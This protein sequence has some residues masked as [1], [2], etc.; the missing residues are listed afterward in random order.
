MLLLAVL[1]QGESYGY[2]LVTRLQVAGLT[3]LSAGTVYPV[4]T[5]L[6]REGEIT[7]RLVA[8]TSG[9]ARKYYSPTDH[10]HAALAGAATA[11]QALAGTV[12]PLLAAAG[13]PKEL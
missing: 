11:W 3:D 6:E 4:L 1:S 10:G 9:P 12:N 13:L 7:S 5:R 2:E 8:S